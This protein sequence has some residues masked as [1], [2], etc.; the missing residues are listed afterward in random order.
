[1]ISIYYKICVDTIIKSKTTNNG[2]WKFSTIL[3]L[4]AFLS[5]IFM[6][7]TISLKSFFP[8]YVNYSLFSDNRIKKSLDIKLEAIILYLVPSLVINYFLII[9]NK[10]YEKLLFNYK[11]SNGKYM[12]RFIIFSL[13]LF[14]ISIFIS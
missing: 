13:I 2:N 12:I 14:L 11:P 5:L 6:S 8:E 9:Y 10:R 1:M 7:I 4:S 3:F